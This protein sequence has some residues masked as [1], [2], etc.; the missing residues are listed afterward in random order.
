MRNM[1]RLPL[2]LLGLAV[3]ACNVPD[4]PPPG[5]MGGGDMST[6][7][8]PGADL[9]MIGTPGSDLLM[10]NSNACKSCM[11]GATM[12]SDCTA[13]L[14]AC[15]EQAQDKSKCPMEKTCGFDLYGGECPM[16]KVYNW[17]DQLIGK[18]WACSGG[19]EIDP[20]MFTPVQISDAG[21]PFRIQIFSQFTG[22][23]SSHMTCVGNI[24]SW[25]QSASPLIQTGQLR[26]LPDGKT[27]VSEI[28]DQGI[29]AKSGSARLVATCTAQ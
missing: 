3:S 19:N 2:L 16:G 22:A 21:E 10:N 9:T 5:T 26:M 14:S 6:V 23:S 17:T 28:F 20:K 29:D 7:A 12:Q 11:M 25:R 1:T 24:C 4:M 8:P 15:Q 27:L 13:L 18:S